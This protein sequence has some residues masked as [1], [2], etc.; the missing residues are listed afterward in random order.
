MVSAHLGRLGIDTLV[1]DRNERVGDNWRSRYDALVLHNKTDMNH[2]AYQPFPDVFPEYLPKDKLGDWLE[3]YAGTLEINCWTST[4]FTGATYDAGAGN[5][6]AS[7]RREDGTERVLR[8]AHIIMATGGV[9]S[10]PNIPDLPGIGN[11]RG[12]VLHTSRFRSGEPYAGRRAL[13][14]GVGAS[15]HDTAHDLVRHRRGGDHGPAGLDERRRPGERQPLVSRLRAG[16][17][18]GRG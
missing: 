10:A 11:F 14:V 18:T 6:V 9:G 13:V 15:G 17:A 2:F 3:A 4:R 12:D 8:P 1:V 16:R 5:W 7:V